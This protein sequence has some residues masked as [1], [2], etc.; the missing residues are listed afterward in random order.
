MISFTGE[1]WPTLGWMALA[2]GV[3]ALAV[4]VVAWRGRRRGSRTFALNAALTIS[5]WWLAATVIGVV[6][7]VVKMFTVDF[8]EFTG[9]SGL[10]LAWP[11]DLDCVDHGGPGDGADGDG[12]AA[13]ITSGAALYCGGSNLS[14]FT[15]AHASAGLRALAGASQLVTAAFTA[16]PAA[17]LAVICW[18]TLRGRAFTRVVTRTLFWGAG[19][20]AFFGVASDLLGGIAATVALREVFPPESEWY[21]WAFQLTVTWW[22]ILAAL[23]LAALAAVFHQGVRLQRDNDVLQ[24]DTE[25][26]V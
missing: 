22:P 17:M 12:A 26:L 2:L 21:P 23:G 20:V 11:A 10:W 7:I 18:H 15:V 3:L 5:G 25:G 1:L 13:D 16:V 9:R 4:G 6:I 14:D 24:H 8:A 19:A